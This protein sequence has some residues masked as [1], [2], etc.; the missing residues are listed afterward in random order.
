MPELAAIR[1]RLLRQLGRAGSLVDA[2]Q[3][4]CAGGRRAAAGRI[5]RKVSRRLRAVLHR[6]RAT[7]RAD[8]P[9][10]AV[11]EPLAD[12]TVRLDAD[13][14]TLARDVTCR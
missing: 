14:G 4:S 9:L 5:L 13:T 2:A 6:L 12:V 7:D 11:V 10:R 1:S 8:V 3:S